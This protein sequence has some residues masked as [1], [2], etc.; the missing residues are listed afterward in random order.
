MLPDPN[1]LIRRHLVPSWKPLESLWFRRRRH[2][3][4]GRYVILWWKWSLETAIELPSCLVYLSIALPVRCLRPTATNNTGAALCNFVPSWFAFPTKTYLGSLRTTP[5]GKDSS[6]SSSW[7]S[8]SSKGLPNRTNGVGK[9]KHLVILCC[10]F[11]A[12]PVHAC[13]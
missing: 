7:S 11:G 8:S 3:L 5:R 2:A 1:W 10:L 12:S 6:L 13:K 4:A 9:C